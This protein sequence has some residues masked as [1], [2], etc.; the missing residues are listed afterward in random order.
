[1]SFWIAKTEEQM[2]CCGG[3]WKL[4]NRVALN[5]HT[6]FPRPRAGLQVYL[7]QM[8]KDAIARLDNYIGVSST[9]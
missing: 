1:M 2:E 3:L 4:N 6:K 7:M 8:K 9:D 5:F